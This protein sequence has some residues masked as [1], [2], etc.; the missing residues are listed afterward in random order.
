MSKNALPRLAVPSEADP[1]PLVLAAMAIPDP[2][3]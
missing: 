1:L 3:F 2:G